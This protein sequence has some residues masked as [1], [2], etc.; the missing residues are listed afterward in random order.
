MNIAE[1][2]QMQDLALFIP[3][4]KTLVFS[5][6]HLGYEEMLASRGTLIPRFQFRDTMMRLEKIFWKIK[7]PLKIIIINGDLKHEFGT[8]SA[9]EW[10]EILKLIDYFSSKCR[11]V[12]I[13]KG[14]HD[15]KLT[16]IARKRDIKIVTSYQLDSILVT[17]GDMLD[18][19]AKDKGIKTIIIGHE[20]PAIMIRSS[21]R[22]EK[23]KCFLKGKY[24]RKT[25]IVQPSFNV[26]A[27][28][29]DI[30]S[31][32]THSP[33]LKSL[34]LD[35]FEVYVAAEEKILYFGNVKDLK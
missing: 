1:D 12:V 2:I 31:E 13:V 35:S 10:R 17:H 23:F 11:E 22:A 7:S 34:S 32:R 30:L 3:K 25:L 28:G 29:T 6:F 5:D 4:H 27:E 33:Y 14:N 9:Q 20:H 26:L 8:I 19:E 16:P 21:T 18:D 24:R 15:V